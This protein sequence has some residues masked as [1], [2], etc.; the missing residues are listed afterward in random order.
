MG[1]LVSAIPLPH[2]QTTPL[3]RATPEPAQLYNLIVLALTQHQPAPDVVGECCGQ[4]R[5]TWPCPQVRHAC[6]L[7]DGL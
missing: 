6:R 4:C 1:T 2:K 5:S 3:D 7:L